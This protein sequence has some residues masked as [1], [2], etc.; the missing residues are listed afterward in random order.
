M[1]ILLLPIVFPILAGTVLFLWKPQNSK[2]RTAYVLTTAT[3]NSLIVFAVFAL[4]GEAEVF[5]IFN[6]AIHIRLCEFI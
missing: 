4:V 6:I 5:T 3:I 2:A 1:S